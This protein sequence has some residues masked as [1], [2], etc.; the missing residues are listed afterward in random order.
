MFFFIII[1]FIAQVIL[2]GF[3]IFW[4]V[5][6]DK[7]VILLAKSLEKSKIKLIWRLRMLEDITSGLNDIAPHIKK[8]IGKSLLKLL[9]IELSEAT[10]Y[11]LV[12]LF[13]PKYKKIVLL[14]KL[15]SGI[16][17]RIKRRLT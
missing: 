14:I 11:S 16:T 1:V 12:L 13:K 7:K 6:Y 2:A 4:I 3:L 9:K 10:V 5:K 15:I 17:K 8:K